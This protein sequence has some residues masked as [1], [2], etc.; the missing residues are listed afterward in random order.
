MRYELQDEFGDKT[1]IDLKHLDYESIWDTLGLK[2]EQKD[3]ANRIIELY[4]S[5]VFSD[6]I[7]IL[8]IYSWMKPHYR[9]AQRHQADHYRTRLE[10]ERVAKDNGLVRKLIHRGIVE[11]HPKLIPYLITRREENDRIL[12][13]PGH[14]RHLQASYRLNVLRLNEMDLNP[15]LNSALN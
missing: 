6:K 15:N 12:I 13:G 1:I 4:N 14:K 3:G 2:N 8:T 11:L 10:L 7:F 5:A 9:E